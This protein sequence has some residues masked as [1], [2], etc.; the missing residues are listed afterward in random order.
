MQEHR[1]HST[2]N[3]YNVLKD[4]LKI[5]SAPSIHLS[6]NH[7]R[8]IALCRFD[9]CL[10]SIGVMFVQPLNELKT[11][12]KEMRVLHSDPHNTLIHSVYSQLPRNR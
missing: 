10:P 9:A 2:Q 11:I 12:R 5:I 1:L 4:H 7:E 6:I 8:I 3:G